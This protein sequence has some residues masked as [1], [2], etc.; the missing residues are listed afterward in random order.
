MAMLWRTSAVGGELLSGIADVI[1]D[2][3]A[4]LLDPPR[5]VAE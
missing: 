2:L 3:P 5:A 4:G 1:R